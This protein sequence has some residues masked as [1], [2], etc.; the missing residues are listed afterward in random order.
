MN[1][2]KDDIQFFSF[3]DI[4]PRTRQETLFTYGVLRQD[5]EITVFLVNDHSHRYFV[6]FSATV[7]LI[8]LEYFELESQL[9]KFNWVFIAGAAYSE[10]YIESKKGTATTLTFE[11]AAVLEPYCHAYTVE[12]YAAALTSVNGVRRALLEHYPENL[13]S[14]FLQGPVK[15]YLAHTPDH[16]RIPLHMMQHPYPTLDEEHEQI[17]LTDAK[18]FMRYWKDQ[19]GFRSI[20]HRLP[21]WLKLDSQHGIDQDDRELLGSPP[22]ESSKHIIPSRM[23]EGLSFS[24]DRKIRFTNGRHRAV[25]IANLGALFIPMHVNKECLEDFRTAFE[26]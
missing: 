13:W 10:I 26:F 24:Q 23:S 5:S 14:S 19:C 3:N 2:D 25:N 9:Q 22:N 7:L 18:K 20:S 11:N 21:R 6:D 1:G 16:P 8:L 15:F 12:R 17:V 4:H